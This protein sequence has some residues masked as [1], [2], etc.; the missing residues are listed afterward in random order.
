MDELLAEYE[1]EIE[2]VTRRYAA[3]LERSA[4]C[5]GVRPFCSRAQR[6]T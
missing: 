2:A 3:R 1:A 4:S 5:G 6:M